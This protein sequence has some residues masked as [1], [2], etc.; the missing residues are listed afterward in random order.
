MGSLCNR[1]GETSLAWK[2][3][4]RALEIS[5]NLKRTPEILENLVGMADLLVNTGQVVEAVKILAFALAGQEMAQDVREQAQ[6]LLATYQAKLPGE[7][8]SAALLNGQAATAEEI[9]QRCL[10]D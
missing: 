3:Y 2:Y 10:S 1:L 5:V 9:L 4:Q 7:D 6:V 8:F